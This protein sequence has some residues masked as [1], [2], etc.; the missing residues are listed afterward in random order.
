MNGVLTRESNEW[1]RQAED[2]TA[3]VGTMRIRA[4]EERGSCGEKQKDLL[5]KHLLII[6]LHPL[7]LNDRGN[8]T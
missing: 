6:D 5:G 8:T 1:I 2:S 3:F 7:E 4:L